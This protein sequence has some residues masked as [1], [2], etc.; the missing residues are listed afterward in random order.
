[1]HGFTMHDLQCLDAVVRAGGFQAAAAVLHRSHPAVFAA[2]TKLEKQLGLTLFDR[3]GYR[4]RLTE[5]GRSFHDR[6]QSLLGEWDGLRTHAAQLAMGEER[7]LRVVI[8]DLCPL[9]ETLGLLSRFF[10]RC[11][12]TRLHLDFETVT[13]PQEKLFDDEADLILHWVEKSDT[14]LEWIDL[15]NVPVLP[16]LSPA[17][18]PAPAV[19][20][21]RP[22]HL[23]GL[24]QCVLRDSAQHSPPRDYFI[25]AGAHQCTVPDLLMKREIIL[26]GMAWGHLPRF[27]I[28]GELRDGRLRSIAGP[29]LAGRVEELVAAR[30]R[31]RPQGP[32]ANRL[33]DYIHGQAPAMRA[34]VRAA[35]PSRKRPPVKRKGRKVD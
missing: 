3:S 12:G 22:E 10:A 1:M 35:G 18:L 25:V 14:R 11:P 5:E 23:R 30:R 28:E 9:P 33:W 27:L 29:C 6:V 2:I 7:A 8:G 20:E 13:G 34:A 24:T 32:V 17:L 16:V 4:V 21:L 31:D 26:Q 19:H 15:C